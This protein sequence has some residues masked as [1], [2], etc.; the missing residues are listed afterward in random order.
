MSRQSRLDAPGVLRPIMIWRIDRRKRFIND[1]DQK[2]MLQGPAVGLA[3][4]MNKMGEKI[5]EIRELRDQRYVFDRRVEVGRM[6]LAM[7]AKS[8]EALCAIN[9]VSG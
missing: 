4:G 2:D 6:V 1:K 8:R 9:P 3:L 5:F 7:L